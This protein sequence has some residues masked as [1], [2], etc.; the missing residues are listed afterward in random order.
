MAY[1]FKNS[2]MVHEI[3]SCIYFDPSKTGLYIKQNIKTLPV[4]VVV[5]VVGEGVQ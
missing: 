2:A 1:G 4:V 3:L 5:V